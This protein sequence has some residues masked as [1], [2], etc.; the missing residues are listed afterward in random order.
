MTSA[1]HRH[2]QDA[3]GTALSR[4]VARFDPSV[5]DVGRP[6]VRIRVEDGG[7]HDVVIEN[8]ETRLEPPRGNP[9]AILTADP[10][11]WSEIAEDVRGGMAAFRRGRLRI[12][13]DLHLGVGF[14][15]ATAMSPA[16]EGRLRIRHVDTAAGRLSTIEAGTGEPVLLI[17]GLGATKASFLPTIDALARSHRPIAV[18]LPGFG[19]SDKPLFGAYD[20]PFFADAMTSLLDALELESAHV[21][22]NSMGGRVALELGLTH[23]DRINRLV[24]LAPS[25]AWLKP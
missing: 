13:R 5:F 19:D 23:P 10:Q 3:S 21:V 7:R 2:N 25:M 24:L 9:D 8:G 18:D 4:L 11:T 22:G 15:A 17:H 1:D 12:R 6:L 16:A 14:L 20:P